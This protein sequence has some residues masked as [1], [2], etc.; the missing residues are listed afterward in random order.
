MSVASNSLPRIL[1]VLARLEDGIL[2]GLLLAM[3]GLAGTQIV[4]RNVLHSGYVDGDQILRILVLWVGLFGAIVASRDDKHISIDLLTRYFSVRL[5][6]VVQVIVHLF[7]G[8]VCGII[9]YHAVRFVYLEYQ[10]G[11]IAF[12]AVA[13][14]MTE[15]I[16]PLAFGLMTLRYLI[17]L[18]F[19]IAA[20]IPRTR[21]T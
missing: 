6:Q 4:L 1:R 15:L 3:I 11:T 18:A 5:G 19:D 17:I 21:P 13:A 2:I 10:G 12:G 14:W 16:L 9:T 7:V 20:M 8:L